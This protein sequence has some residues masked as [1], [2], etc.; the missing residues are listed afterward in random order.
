MVLD[1]KTLSLK[2]CDAI[3]EIRRDKLI[4]HLIFQNYLGNNLIRKQKIGQRI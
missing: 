1:V 2:K 3:I 4:H